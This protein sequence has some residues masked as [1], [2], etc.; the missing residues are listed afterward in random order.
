M[1]T[2]SL[3]PAVSAIGVTVGLVV[4]L[5]GVAVHGAETFRSVGGVIVLL[6]IGLLT[7]FL[8]GIEGDSE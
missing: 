1:A 3:T 2:E 7:V 4:L 5:F 8:L 6:S